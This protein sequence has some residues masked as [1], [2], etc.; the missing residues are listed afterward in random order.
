MPPPPCLGTQ[1]VSLAQF[2]AA[3]LTADANRSAEP[4]RLEVRSSG[5]EE[6]TFEI[7]CKLPDRRRKHCS[8]VLSFHGKYPSM[9]MVC[10]VRYRIAVKRIEEDSDREDDEEFSAEGFIVTHSTPTHN[11]PQKYPDPQPSS[12]VQISFARNPVTRSQSASPAAESSSSDSEVDSPRSTTIFA[13]G[14]W[15]KSRTRELFKGIP[16]ISKK[17]RKRLIRPALTPN[18]VEEYE[19]WDKILGVGRMQDYVERIGWGADSELGLAI[20]RID[21]PRPLSPVKARTEVSDYEP[22]QSSETTSVPISISPTSTKPTIP[23]HRPNRSIHA[24]PTRSSNRLTASTAK[25]TDSIMPPIIIVDSP[26]VT[27]AISEM[28][29]EREEGEMEEGEIEEM[30]ETTVEIISPLFSRDFVDTPMTDYETDDKDF[31]IVTGLTRTEEGPVRGLGIAVEQNPLSFPFSHIPSTSTF[32]R[33]PSPFSTLPTA[34]TSMNVISGKK[35]LLELCMDR[36]RRLS[37]TVVLDTKN[38]RCS[39]AEGDGSRDVEMDLGGWFVDE[40]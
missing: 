13:N 2:E 38:R 34:T 18:A 10:V 1:F 40:N 7:V 24:L 27:A 29:Q 15:R 8:F 28:E 3:T 21:E 6:G 26:R 9:L 4:Y 23:R 17:R 16:T 39:F 22:E 37:T 20:R 31:V 14:R 35:G 32:S 36:E 12:P 33:R 11:H 30:R 19:R 5:S 25:K